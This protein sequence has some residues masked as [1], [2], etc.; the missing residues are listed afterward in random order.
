MLI[1][2]PMWDKFQQGLTC[3]LVGRK[4]TWL[5]YVDGLY[6]SNQVL[7]LLIS[8]LFNDCLLMSKLSWVGLMRIFFF[9]KVVGSCIVL[10]V[11]IL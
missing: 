8:G 2:G 4:S 9:G 11:L 3:I 6:L 1:N 5:V 7:C 10:L